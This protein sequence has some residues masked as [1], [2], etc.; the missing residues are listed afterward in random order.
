MSAI[1]EREDWDADSLTNVVGS[2][3]HLAYHL[4]AIRQ[5]TQAAAGPKAAD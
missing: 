1:G 2:L 5:L 4:G 3:A